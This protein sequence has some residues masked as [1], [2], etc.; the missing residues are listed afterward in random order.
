M[1]KILVVAKLPSEELSFT[2]CAIINIRDFDK[3]TTK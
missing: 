3:V 1:A 2:N